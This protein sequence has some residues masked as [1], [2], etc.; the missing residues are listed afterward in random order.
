MYFGSKS[1]ELYGRL[2]SKTLIM[3][4]FLSILEK[5]V[6]MIG[7]LPHFFKFCIAKVFL[8]LF[9]KLYF[10]YYQPIKKYRLYVFCAKI[11]YLFHGFD[12]FGFRIHVF[13]E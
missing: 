12:L 4:S 9:F 8:F 10:I 7:F 1:D 6:Y 13:I 5:S 2:F 3:G 11:V